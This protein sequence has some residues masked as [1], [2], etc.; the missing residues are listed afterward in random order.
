MIIELHRDLVLSIVPYLSQGERALLRL[1]SSRFR[2][3]ISPTPVTSTAFVR[4]LRLLKWVRTQG[5][6]F[7]T[8]TV[9]QA[10]LQPTTGI[11]SS[12]EVLDYLLAEGCSFPQS[13][14]R[15][16]VFVTRP[17]KDT[18]A[19]LE[20]LKQHDLL[21]RTDATVITIASRYVFLDVFLWL[22]E[23]GYLWWPGTCAYAAASGSSPDWRQI[24]NVITKK[25][26]SSRRSA[27]YGAASS[28]YQDRLEILVNAGFPLEN[29]I[30]I[31]AIAPRNLRL[32]EYLRSQGTIML[33][34]A[35]ANLVGIGVIELIEW[36]HQYFT[37]E[38]ELNPEHIYNS[39]N[40]SIVDW[41][42]RNGYHFAPNII[43]QIIS[44]GHPRA[45]ALLDYIHPRMTS[46]DRYAWYDAMDNVEMTEW[47]RRHG[48]PN[49]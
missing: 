42:Y 38:P 5:C 18:L 11:S 28:G 8:H 22:M 2:S 32:L 4:D 37:F 19:L 40:E 26:P 6:P 17:A 16:V 7:D 46:L 24:V 49:V 3:L 1:T 30:Y 39:F 20:W 45:V 23:Q 29:G 15:I 47:L 41:V 9:R 10:L 33:Q 48:Y 44:S 36:A 31:D 34:S 14:D 12:T 35:F 27:C 13:V 21:N 43:G 25:E